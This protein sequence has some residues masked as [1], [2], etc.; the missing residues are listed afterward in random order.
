M[1]CLLG[2]VNANA[3]A[4]P[5]TGQAVNECE[6]SKQKEAAFSTVSSQMLHARGQA[7]RF[8]GG[9]PGGEGIC[10]C[11]CCCCCTRGPGL[12]VQA[13]KRGN[14]G[15]HRSLRPNC[16]RVS[17]RRESLHD[18]RRV[19]PTDSVRQAGSPSPKQ[20]LDTD[21]GG[22]R[23]CEWSLRAASS[24]PPRPN[25]ASPAI[26]GQRPSAPSAVGRMRSA[27]LRSRCLTMLL[28]AVVVAFFVP[29]FLVLHKT[30]KFG[31]PGQARCLCA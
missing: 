20:E 8:G 30:Q 31:R 4:P 5:V 9:A 11:C 17:G 29:L 10:C 7:A 28:I 16:H 15:A 19:L 21:A 13:R 23:W 27:T 3:P 6:G 25:L 1:R 18:R 12:F 24:T 2:R 22:H 14:A 26:L